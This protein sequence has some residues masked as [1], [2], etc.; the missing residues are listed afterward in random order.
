MG[1]RDE[2]FSRCYSIG[3]AA[4]PVLGL[5]EPLTASEHRFNIATLVDMGNP[6]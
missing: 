1:L 3:L 6:G 4:G 2:R 5:L